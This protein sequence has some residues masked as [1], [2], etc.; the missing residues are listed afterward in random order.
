MT[1]LPLKIA[2]ATTAGA[3]GLDD[4]MAPLVAALERLVVDVDV[5]D[6]DSGDVDWSSYDVVVLRS[7]WDYTN[8]PDQFRAWTERVDQETCLLNPAAIVAW[9]IDKHY[10]AE[11]QQVGIAIVPTRYVEPL[12][13]VDQAIRAILDEFPDA[14]DF[15]VKPCIGAGSR[16]ARRHAR[17]DFA[18]AEAHVE[19]LLAEQ[20][21]VMLQPYLERVDSAGETALLH[22]DGRFSHAI[23]KGPLLQ[24]GADSTTQLFAPEQI[25]ARIPRADEHELAERVVAAIPGDQAM[26]YARIDLIRDNEGAPQLLELELVEPSLFFAQCGHSEDRFAAAVVARAHTARSRR[27]EHGQHS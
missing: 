20:R 5:V 14:Q 11:L 19:R 8:R 4:D 12:D 16:D 24:R 2:L 1:T 3:R 22:F 15:V 25:E 17:A 6:W 18:V 21:S 9:N 13:P 10:L 27:E 26:L 23:R 7:T